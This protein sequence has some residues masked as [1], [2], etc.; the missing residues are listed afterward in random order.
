MTGKDL[1]IFKG[2]TDIVTGVAFSPDGKYL[3]TS[4]WDGT[5][6]LWDVANGKEMPPIPRSYRRLYMVR[7]SHPMVNTS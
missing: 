5:V 2:H 1:M 4:S 3:L 6:R 7:L